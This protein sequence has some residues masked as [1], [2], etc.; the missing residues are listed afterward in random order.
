[1]RKEWDH[2]QK[3][4]AGKTGGGF[5]VAAGAAAL[6]FICLLLKA[7]VHDDYGKRTAN[8]DFEQGG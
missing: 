4:Q 2:G 5:E 3:W 7:E 6:V 1:M 8:P